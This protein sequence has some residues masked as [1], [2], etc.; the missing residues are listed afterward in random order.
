MQAR[1]TRIG[2]I[3]IVVADI[4]RSVQ[5]YTEVVGLSLTERFDYGPDEVGHGVAVS[6][7][8]FLRSDSTHHCISIFTFRGGVE[9]PEPGAERLP[10]G[11]HHVAFEMPTHETL[12]QIYRRLREREVPIVNA[13]QG[14]PG[15]QPRFYARDPD[16]HLLEFYWG[17]DQIGWDG[18]PREYG[19]IE[20]VD[21]E[22]FDFDAFAEERDRLSSAAE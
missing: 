1:P 20:E 14:G 11:L 13:R 19:P 7:G 8:A 2:H 12:L 3:G 18:R 9:A 5:F 16:G 10:Y 22:G 15:N 4:D 6:G 21:L 17:I